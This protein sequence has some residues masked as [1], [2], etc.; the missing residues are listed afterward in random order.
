MP[1]VAVLLPHSYLLP[2]TWSLW[3]FVAIMGFSWW[4]TL[5]LTSSL[6]AEVYGLHHLGILNG[7]AFTGHQIGGALSIQLGG[8]LRDLTG[9]YDLPFTVATLLLV[10]ASLA[11]FAIHERQYSSRYQPVPDFPVS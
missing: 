5:P 7:V 4:A 6:T 8:L 2:G 1:C 11:S 10:G 3:S 9:S